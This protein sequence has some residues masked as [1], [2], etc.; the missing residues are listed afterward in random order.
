VIMEPP[1]FVA[2]KNDRSLDLAIYAGRNHIK[3]SAT[4]PTACHSSPIVRVT[5]LVTNQRTLSHMLC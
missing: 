3:H 2:D 5:H 1:L 4:P